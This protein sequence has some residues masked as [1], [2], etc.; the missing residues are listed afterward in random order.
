LG[1]K[2][3]F[4]SC[5][6]VLELGRGTRQTDGPTDT[7]RQTFHRPNAPSLVPT[8]VSGKLKPMAKTDRVVEVDATIQHDTQASDQWKIIRLGTISV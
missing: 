1:F 8:E 3:S 6:P 4:T 7:D 5:F 2:V